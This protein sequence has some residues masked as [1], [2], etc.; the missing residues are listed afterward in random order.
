MNV[1]SLFDGMS[2]GQI[3]LERSGIKVTNYFAS[4]IDKYVIQV[5]QKNYP[6]TK[7]L[8]SVLNL[9]S[10]SIPDIDLLIGGS[11]CTNLSF[12]GNMK[13]LSTKSNIEIK[14]LYQ[15]INLKNE[16]FE[17]EGQ[18]Y[19][20]WEYIRMLNLKKPK[21]FL[22]ENVVMSKKWENTF[23]KVM[24]FDPERINSSFF[25]AQKRRRLYW[26][27][28]IVNG[29]YKKINISEFIDKNITLK[30]V[31][32]DSSDKSIDFKYPSKKRMEYIQRKIDNGWL[33]K[34][35]NT[36]DTEKS[37]CLLAS[38]YKQLQEFVW[39]DSEGLRFFH[40]NEFESLQTVPKNYTDN[41]S[42]SQRLKM[43]GN[44]W[45]IDVISH[46]FNHLK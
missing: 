42:L 15:Y 5:T 4:E 25:S 3:A 17:F 12:A 19:L 46:L 39:K 23:S 9:D 6:D 10:D 32:F 33:K 34:A 30:D 36:V 24:G 37:E 8:G 22:L 35:F 44:G 18:S 14:T 38:M 43:L 26:F 16:G 2:C 11:P 27:G 21:Y 20:F 28:E 29:E 13:G 7:Q 31:M 45:T 40:I 1:L 41:V